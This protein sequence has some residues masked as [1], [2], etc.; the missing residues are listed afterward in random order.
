M[1]QQEFDNFKQRLKDW[2]NSHQE[3]YDRFE[4]DM[5]QRNPAGYQNIMSKAM[6]LVPEY[7]KILK[8]K[9]DTG[10]LEDITD[11]ETLFAEKNLVKTLIDEF[12]NPDENSIV[13]SAL[14]WLYFGKSFERMVEQGEK[15]KNNTE[16][17]F[18][19]KQ[20][21]AFT[22]KMIISQSVRLGLRTK[23]DWNKYNKLKKAIDNNQIIDWAL[24]QEEPDKII[25]D[26]KKKPGRKSNGK[27]FPGMLS[28]SPMEQ[29]N[30]LINRIGEFLITKNSK[31]DLALLK[32][33]LEE[34][35]Y[36]LPCDVKPFR[37]ALALQ[38]GENVHIIVE[39][40]IQDAY[41]ELTDYM[42][43]KG[44]LVKDLLEN[45]VQIEKIKEILSK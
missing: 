43:S 21:Y 2:M 42:P 13:P 18:F 35:F 5:N 16:V 39:R 1:G 27:T 41:K 34:L 10:V 14:C 45:R 29:P 33:A 26:E 9:M 40:G 31:Q 20:L 15:M 19:K 17:S 32:I 7:Q 12:E 37:D 30:D 8:K 22:I 11:I 23:E 38:Y 36:I 24:D 4:E 3:D 6:M 44:I 28:E 25:A